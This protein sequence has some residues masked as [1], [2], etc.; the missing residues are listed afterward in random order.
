MFDQN[1][2]RR[3]YRSRTDR[4]ISGVSGGLAAYLNV[5]PTIVRI[6]WVVATFVTFPMAPIAYVILA[7]LIPQE[8][9]TSPTDTFMI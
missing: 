9:V 8:P 2:P 5:D 3:L 4:Q 6:M 1:S 7:A